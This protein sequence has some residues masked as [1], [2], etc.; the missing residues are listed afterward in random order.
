MKEGEKMRPQQVEEDTTVTHVK[1]RSATRRPPIHE[2]S[3]SVCT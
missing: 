1:Q 3:A 2:Y